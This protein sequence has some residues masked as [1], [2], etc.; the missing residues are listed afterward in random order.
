MRNYRIM[1]K[2]KSVIYVVVLIFFADF[3]GR[4][5][6]RLFLTDPLEPIFPDSN[7]LSNYSNQYTLDFPAGT[8]ADVHLLVDA[9]A[10]STFSVTAFV[11][12][13][14]LPLSCWST[15]LDVPVE[16]NTGLDSRT[17]IY[18]GINNPYVIRR[19]PFRIYEAILPLN[20]NI[21]ETKSAFTALRFAAP[22]EMLSEPGNYEINFLIEGKGWKQTGRF[23][24]LV[25]P[26]KLPSLKD[27]RFF[28]T[29]SFS[30]S[31]M[32]IKHQL[33]RWTQP[34]YNML[35]KYARLMAYGRQNCII[36]PSELIT[37]KDGKISLDEEKMIRF[38]KVFQQYGF[39]YFESPH[40]M[41]RGDN[42]DWGDAELKTALTKKRYY[43]QEAQNDI[44]TLITLI[45]TFAEKY[46]LTHNWL[47]HISDEPTVTQA[48]CYRDVV[49]QVKSIYP[50]IHIMEATNDRD[51]LVGAVDLWCPLINDFQ[52]HE[53]FF[54]EREKHHEKI[55]V[56]TCLI[57]GGQWLNRLLDEE[58]L[59]EVYFGWGAAYYNLFGF[60]HWGFNQYAA[61]PFEQSVVH[62]PAPGAASNN[63]LPAGDT[64]VIYPGVDGPL[65]STRFEAH[66]IGI[67]D[68]ELLEQLKQTDSVK[69]NK[70]ISHLFTS[71]TEYNKSVREYRETRK[72]LLNSFKN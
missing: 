44:D 68:Y 63:F 17:E 72:Q 42:D 29:N 64:H 60:L 43:T 34:W 41:Y 38:I 48:R 3:S 39:K 19:A 5:Q 16:Q 51:S 6:G 53:I 57:P 12:G 18:K 7:D 11:K 40:L 35:D 59:R 14:A 62:H 21:I 2:V 22:A 15:L 70:L 45:K 26:A 69:A 65:S 71:F 13:K 37:L 24:A 27:N 25:H 32:E 47:Q 31:Q 61:N 23:M 52:E 56:Y 46:Q 33:E 55:L 9:P 28:Y 54:R 1:K 49:K 67:E 4:A 20:K 58:R 36:I 10:G 50:E 66:R 30:L 8:V